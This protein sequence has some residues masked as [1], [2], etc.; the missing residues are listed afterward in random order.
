MILMFGDIH[1]D[2]RHVLP[3]VVEHRPKAIILLG[4]IE[5]SK[6]LER[7]LESVLSKT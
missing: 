2:F 1:G 5:A 4:D 6:P 7:E 3:A